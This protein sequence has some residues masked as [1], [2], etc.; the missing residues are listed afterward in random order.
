MG[1]EGNL[2]VSAGFGNIDVIDD[3]GRRS[4][5]QGAR[6][7]LQWIGGHVGG[8]AEE[9]DLHLEVRVGKTC[10]A[11]NPGWG[12]TQFVCLFVCLYFCFFFFFF[13]ARPEACGDS[14]ARG[15]I[16]AAAAGLYPARATQDP[17]CVSDLHHSSQ[18]RWVLNP[19]SE[20]RDRTHILVDTTRIY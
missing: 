16:R 6:S 18:Q 20:A 10:Q 13:R 5:C 15:Q 17:S 19:L 11:E 14:Q 12:I 4:L 9:L 3:F 7:G 8:S 2:R 1:R